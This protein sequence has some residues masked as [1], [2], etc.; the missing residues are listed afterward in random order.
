MQVFDQEQRRSWLSVPPA[1]GGLC[2]IHA[3]ACNSNLSCF[4]PS[5]G[6]RLCLLQLW[7]YLLGRCLFAWQMP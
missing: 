7:P 1:E 2:I 3:G 6:L 5:T 4:L